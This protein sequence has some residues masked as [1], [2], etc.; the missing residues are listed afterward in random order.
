MRELRH[1]ILHLVDSFNQ[2]GTERQAVQLIRMLRESG[3]FEVHVACLSREGILRNELNIASDDEPPEFPLSSFYDLNMVKQLRRFVRLLRRRRITLVHTHDFYTNIFGMAAAWLA[4]VPVRIA[5]RRETTGL[6]TGAQKYVE[7]GAY[8]LAHKV[9]ANAGAVERQLVTE[10]LKAEKISV[11]HN[12]LGLDRL[13]RDA[14]GSRYGILEKLGLPP[15]TDRKFVTI[16]ANLHSDVKD[17]AMFLRM[18]KRVREAVPQAV[19]VIAG[20]GKL[21]KSYQALAV[22]LGIERDTFFVGRCDRIAELLAISNVGV[23]TSKAEGFSNSILEYMAA[24]LPV[25]VTDVGGAREMVTEGVTGFLVSSGDDGW[26]ARRVVEMLNNPNRACSMGEQGRVVTEK[27]FSCAQ[28]LQ[29]TVGLYRQLLAT[30][31]VSS[32][33]VLGRMGHEGA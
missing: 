8:R 18:A 14:I 23:L 19:F 17:H 12:G 26:M 13:S 30:A 25:V 15:G 32:H 20:E 4:R 7:H 6:R 1:N 31:G 21:L 9:I 29:R 11:I 3:E 22:E 24:S 27:R 2:G 28:Q 5:S 33:A 16:V 10:G